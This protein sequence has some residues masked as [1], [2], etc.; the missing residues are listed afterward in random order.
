MSAG[1]KGLLL[2][3]SGAGLASLLEYLSALQRRI[4]A[5]V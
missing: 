1:I 2:P 4:H 3:A 5:V